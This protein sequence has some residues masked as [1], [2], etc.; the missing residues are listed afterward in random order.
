M[1]GGPGGPG[2]RGQPFERGG[3]RGHG[4]PGE[5]GP[6]GGPAEPGAAR[7]RLFVAVFPPPGV[8]AAAH[9][10]GAALR[11]DR[12]GVAWVRSANLHFTLRFLGDVDAAGAAR[13]AAAAHHAAGARAA[14]EC[15]LGRPGAFPDARR[16]RVIWLGLS[17]GGDA[18]V[19]L[20]REL[21]SSLRRHGFAA[22][23][24]PFQP[25]LTLGRA[26][27]D[28]GD[29]SARFAARD[30]PEEGA[31]FRVDRIAVV[32]SRLAPGGSIYATQSEAMLA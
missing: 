27:G 8:Q 30:M 7:E 9:A 16:A 1:S 31:R 32:A 17:A 21:E 22:A 25:H 23:D 29:W 14:F 11:S 24:R 5:S 3:S 12:D 13:I 15:A 28:G 2:G 4:G 10:I 18:L 6:S 19:A 26:R 20:A